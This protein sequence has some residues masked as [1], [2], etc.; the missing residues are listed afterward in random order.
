MLG[1][2]L[3]NPWPAPFDLLPPCSLSPL[4]LPS[5]PLIHCGIKILTSQTPRSLSSSLA[6]MVNRERLLGSILS[7]VKQFVYKASLSKGLSEQASREAGGKIFTFGSYRFVPLSCLLSDYSGRTGPEK[8]ET[9]TD[10]LAPLEGWASMDQ[11][12]ILICCAS[13]PSI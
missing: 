8:D 9:R 3:V 10:D 4:L 7:L 6:P 11:E 2:V 13:C 5:T 1:R 12:R